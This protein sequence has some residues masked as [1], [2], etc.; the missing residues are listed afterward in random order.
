MRALIPVG[1]DLPATTAELRCASSSTS[2]SRPAWLIGL[3]AV[4]SMRSVRA[5]SAASASA[6]IPYGT[7]A[8]EDRI[9]VTQNA[10]DFRRL[11][12]RV[13]L[14]PGLIIL[15]ATAVAV[16]ISPMT[17][18]LAHIESAS[19]GNPRNWT[20]NRVVEIDEEGRAGSEALPPA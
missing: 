16:S 15:P 11:V 19:A 8:S 17:F 9:I 10:G 6:T 4:A 13:E 2:A 20:S 1:A 14:H 7:A 5:T 3:R 12:G 18:A